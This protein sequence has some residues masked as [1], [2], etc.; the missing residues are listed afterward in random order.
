MYDI[1]QRK[2]LAQYLVILLMESCKHN[3][4]AAIK[5][6]SSLRAASVLQDC[7]LLW[8]HTL[9]R[10]KLMPSHSPLSVQRT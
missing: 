6:E 1:I 7:S 5:R 3:A 9:G 8:K 4:F 2:Q 10:K